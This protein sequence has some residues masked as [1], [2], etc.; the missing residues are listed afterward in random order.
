LTSKPDWRKR[1]VKGGLGPDDQTASTPCGRNALHASF[2]PA[3]SYSASLALRVSPS[4]PLSTSSRIASNVFGCARMVSNTSV[5]TI[6]TRRSLR[7]SPKISA[8]GPL[9]QATTAGTS[10]ATSTRAP[11]PSTA[12]AARSVKPMP[13]PPISTCGFLIPS[14][15]LAA[16]VASA[17]SEP[18]RRLFINSLVPSLMENSAPRRISR[19]SPSLPGMRAVSILTHGIMGAF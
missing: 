8:I 17:A 12:S 11:G 18:L 19:N 5:S 1:F 6:L 16:S 10:S 15:F 9:A 2:S 4:G 13:R 3:E 7:L 14:I